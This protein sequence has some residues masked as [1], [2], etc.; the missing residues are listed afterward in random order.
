[1]QTSLRPVAAL[2]G[3]PPPAHAACPGCGSRVL[4]FC[5][6]RGFDRCV[7][8]W[9]H[10]SR[11]RVLNDITLAC[12]KMAKVAT[13]SSNEQQCTFECGKAH[14]LFTRPTLPSPHAHHHHPHRHPSGHDAPPPAQF[15]APQHLL[16]AEGPGVPWTTPRGPPRCPGPAGWLH[17]LRRW[18]SL[19]SSVVHGTRHGGRGGCC[20]RGGAARGAGGCQA[21]W[22]E[23]GGVW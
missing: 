4:S 21:A 5:L 15:A 14:A 2:E 6:S 7:C 13:K 8:N 1:M 3:L 16:A 19:P 9:L 18:I 12:E 11:A 17:P 10:S 22:R 23:Q 20:G